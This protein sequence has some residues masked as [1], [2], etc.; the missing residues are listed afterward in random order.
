[1]S[2]VL[3]NATWCHPRVRAGPPRHRRAPSKR[4]D[5]DA[6][7]ALDLRRTRTGRS[8]RCAAR[9][10]SAAPH[11]R[12]RF[13]TPGRFAGK[14]VVVTGAAQGIGEQTARRISAEGGTLVLADRS[15]LVKELAD[16]LAR[17]EVPSH[18]R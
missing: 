7:R 15:E 13:V 16:E 1:M 2:E 18:S 10:Q 5:R 9:W 17:T 3:R 14:V 4:G 12:P 11:E 8:R 6:A